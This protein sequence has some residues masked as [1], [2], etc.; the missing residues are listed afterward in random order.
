MFI[1]CVYTII[2]EYRTVIFDLKHWE[3][4]ISR[5]N[6]LL[7]HIAHIASRPFTIYSLFTVA[8]STN[9]QKMGNGYLVTSCEINLLLQLATNEIFQH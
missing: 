3:V 2:M 5:W 1:Y 7:F 8:E 4:W 6:P 9:D